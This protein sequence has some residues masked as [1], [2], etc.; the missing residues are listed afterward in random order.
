MRSILVTSIIV[1]T[2]LVYFSLSNHALHQ[3]KELL[4]NAPENQYFYNIKLVN[5]YLY[6]ANKEKTSGLISF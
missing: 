5:P 4:S 2:A 6:L 3:E 1:A